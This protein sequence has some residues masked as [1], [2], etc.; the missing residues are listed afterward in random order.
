MELVIQVQDAEVSFIV[1]L[2]KKFDFVKVKL[3]E[4]IAFSDSL[5]RSLNQMQAMRTGQIPKPTLAE[6][7]ENE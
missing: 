5:E 1:E 7:F 4:N 6:L 3:S 2:L